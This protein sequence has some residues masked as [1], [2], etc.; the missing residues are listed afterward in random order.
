MPEFVD[1][2]RIYIEASASKGI[3]SQPYEERHSKVQMNKSVFTE[4]E[5]YLLLFFAIILPVSIYGYMMWKRAISSKSVLFFGVI[6]IIFAGVSIFLLQRL[7]EIA[8]I[9]PS[10]LGHQIF[11]SEVSIALYLLPALFAG[12]GV[13][14]VSDSLIKHLTKAEKQYDREHR[15]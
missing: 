8:K 2:Y 15:N 4:L 1:G 7:N 13:N 14:L 11:A 6:L 9:S 10:M 3:I 12:I 5:F